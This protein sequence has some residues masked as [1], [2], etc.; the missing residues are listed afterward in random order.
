VARTFERSE[1]ALDGRRLGMLRRLTRACLAVARAL[2]DDAL[3][4]AEAGPVLLRALEGGL[5]F[6]ATGDPPPGAL[7]RGAHEIGFAAA[8]GARRLG[9]WLLPS[10]PLQAA[11]ALARSSPDISDQ[12]RQAAVTRLIEGARRTDTEPEVRAV[13]LLGLGLLTR[14]VGAGRVRLSADDAQRAL[15]AWSDALRWPDPFPLSQLDA[16]QAGAGAGPESLHDPRR[17]LCLRVAATVLALEDQRPSYRARIQGGGSAADL[18][19]LADD[20]GRRLLALEAA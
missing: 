10:D 6:P 15:E 3:P 17:A 16:L 2:L 20:L 5:P 9:R 19:R 4:L 11:A 8:T 1:R 13:A 18:G 7:L 12:E 14:E